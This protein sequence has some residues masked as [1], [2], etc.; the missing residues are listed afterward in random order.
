MLGRLKDH[1][2]F[3]V[4]LAWSM[5][6]SKLPFAIVVCMSVVVICGCAPKPKPAGLV[7]FPIATNTS[8]PQEEVLPKIT[9]VE[10]DEIRPGIEVVFRASGG[11]L[12]DRCGGQNESARL[13]HLYFDDEPV[14]ELSCYV[15][16][17]EGKY[18]VP[19]STAAGRHCVGVQKGSCQMELDVVGG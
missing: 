5:T 4:S 12:R 7:A 19:E 6:G 9:D 15:N 1:S 8:C 14:A 13:Y 11:Y 16:H 2:R 3:L 17:C 18:R 10:P